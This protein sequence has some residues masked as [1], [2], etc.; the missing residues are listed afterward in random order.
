M[1]TAGT[2]VESNRLKLLHVATTLHQDHQGST[3]VDAVLSGLV[4]DL[5][6]PASVSNLKA[7]LR[8]SLLVLVNGR[9]DALRTAVDTVY[10][11]TFGMRTLTKSACNSHTCD[12]VRAL[13]LACVPNN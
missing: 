4:T 9:A 2:R 12:V 10:G 3:E 11:W 1:S 8:D 5:P 13:D 6:P 7:S